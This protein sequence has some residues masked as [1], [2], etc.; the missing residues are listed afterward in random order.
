MSEHNYD[1]VDTRICLDGSHSL[2]VKM[3]VTCNQNRK[4]ALQWLCPESRITDFSGSLE[5]AIK[6]NR[7]VVD[8]VGG[9]AAML[10]SMN[11]FASCYTN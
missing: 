5:S 1:I 10:E 8:L 9:D 2:A 4:H 6:F 7:F 11:D 3:N